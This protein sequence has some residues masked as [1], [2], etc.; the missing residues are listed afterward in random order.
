MV[1]K[2]TKIKKI[3][4]H[5]DKLRTFVV[6]KKFDI[7]PGQFAKVWIP[8]VDTKPISF[9]D[10]NSITV[11]KMPYNKKKE[12]GLFTHELFNKKEGDYLHFSNPRGKGFP[13]DQN[14]DY[15]IIAGGVGIAPLNSLIINYRCK[16]A[17]LAAKT[18]DELLFHK[19]IH[20]NFR[21]KYGGKLI[22]MTEDGSIGRKGIP[23]DVNIPEADNYAICGPEKMIEAV[24]DKINY[25][26]NTYVSLERRMKCMEGLCGACAIDG[27]TVCGDGPVFRYDKIKN[28][29]SFRKHLGR[30]KTGK[31]VPLKDI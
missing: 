1:F 28:L 6:N 19:E 7:Y 22:L 13:M 26:E 21:V 11:K 31:L 17:I 29:R 4:E 27:Y 3:I 25:P 20:K 9:S 16:N 8:G 2:V 12:K 15:T 18:K 24:A 5:S 10:V 14:K 30:D 23:I